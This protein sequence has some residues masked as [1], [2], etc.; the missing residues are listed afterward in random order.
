MN[1]LHY[2]SEAKT[3]LEEIKNYIGVELASPIAAKN[4]VTKITKRVRSLERFA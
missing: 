1:K 4:T 2:S 3:D